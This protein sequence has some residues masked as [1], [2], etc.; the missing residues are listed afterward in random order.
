V[1]DGLFGIGLQRALDGVYAQWVDYINGQTAPVLAL[2]VP[3]GLH[4]DSGCVLGRA[5]RADHTM[6]FIAL[7]PGLL[8]LD[9]PDQCGEVHVA[10][11]G[12]DVEQ[13]VA[14]Q[15]HTIGRAILSQCLPRRPANSHKGTFGS[16]GIVGGAPGMYGAALLA[17][18]AA[19]KLGAGRVYL[20]GLDPSGARVDPLQPELM[21][22]EA[23]EVL[24]M[25]DLSCLVLGPGLSR[26][27]RAHESVAR[28][29]RMSVPAVIDADALNLIGAETP[30]QDA[31]RNRSAPTLLTP[32]PAE[33]ARLRQTTTAEIQR[34]RIGSA[35]A[36][37]QQY[38][39]LVALKGAGTVVAT[40]D[41][42]LYINT[43]GNPGLASA[44]MGD[45][46]SGMIGALLSQV[47]SPECAICAG[48]HLHGAAADA[49]WGEHG[50]PIG[51]TGTE[52][53]DAARELLNRAIYADSARTV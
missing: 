23:D 36:V 19:L 32:H 7:K 1:V 26:S 4:S 6:T 50:G 41:A 53:T 29:L 49:L 48:V 12:L 3:S 24:G 27:D 30:L 52:V 21:L 10:S 45:V 20:G 44:G 25:Q 37:A 22:R 8:T 43:S 38:R 17:G 9:G 13:H 46:L 15:G 34:D 39:A 14:A 2:D 16:V 11:L 51:M 5:V 42:R 18:R 35:R 28:A 31:C 33:A 47:A 40:P